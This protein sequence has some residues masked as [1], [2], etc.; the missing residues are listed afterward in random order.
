MFEYFIVA[1]KMFNKRKIEK[2]YTRNGLHKH[3]VPSYLLLML[4]MLLVV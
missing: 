4:S 1:Y 2:L 3:H